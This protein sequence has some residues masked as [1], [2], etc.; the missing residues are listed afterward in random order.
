M[1]KG[2]IFDLDG[3]IL[4]TLVDLGNSVNAVLEDYGYPTHNT[5]DY[6]KKVGNGVRKL[7]ERS[8]PSNVKEDE[9]DE[10]LEKFSYYYDQYCLEN[11]KPY[12]G[13]VEL[14]KALEERGVL[15]AVN[16]N[17]ID[18][19]TKDLVSKSFPTVPFVEVLGQRIAVPVKPNPAGALEIKEKMNLELD[20]ILFVGDS[21]VD[22]QTARNAGMKVVV[23]PWGFRPKEELEKANP[24]YM[25]EKASDLLD[26]LD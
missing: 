13:I 7:L 8:L 14:L 24:D 10:A 26:L 3:T 18:R 5:E 25:I 17:K 1:I 6:K 9:L 19:Y 16:S 15:L 23:V 4:D 22:I 21:E 12:P 20:E 2:I 11:S